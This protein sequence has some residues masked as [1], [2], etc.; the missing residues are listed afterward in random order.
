MQSK[1]KGSASA[2]VH[3]VRKCVCRHIGSQ[4]AR[5]K[6]PDI[7]GCLACSLGVRCD[8]DDVLCCLHVCVVSVAAARSLLLMP[9]WTL[10]A[11]HPLTSRARS[12][13]GPAAMCHI[14]VV[15][16]VWVEFVWVAGC[17]DSVTV[18]AGE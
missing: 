9:A 5:W 12:G 18:T 17:A 6:V 3:P 11:Y 1:T 8:A 2:G 4:Q 16:L 13:T 10:T 15:G 14:K 7:T